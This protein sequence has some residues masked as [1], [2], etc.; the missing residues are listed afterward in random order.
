MNRESDAAI[1]KTILS[2]VRLVHLNTS[3]VLKVR[4]RCLTRATGRACP[5][6]TAVPSGCRFH[7]RWGLSKSSEL[8]LG[9]RTSWSPPARAW[10]APHALLSAFQLS[11]AHLPDW[12]FRQLE[13][14]GEKLPRGSHESAVWTVEEHRYGRSEC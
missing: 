9:M 12:G 7:G 11:G 3:A 1:W 8:S 2:E 4:A 6:R 13:V 14:V 5:S 10:L